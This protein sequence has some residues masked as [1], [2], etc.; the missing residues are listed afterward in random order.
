M[1]VTLIEPV[2]G[3]NVSSTGVT[4]PGFTCTSVDPVYNSVSEAPYALTLRCQ[5]PIATLVNLH[6]AESPDCTNAC[7]SV[8]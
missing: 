1:T 6:V 8:S 3:F 7:V 5:V 2:A 4:R